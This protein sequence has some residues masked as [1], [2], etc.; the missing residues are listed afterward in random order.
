[1]SGPSSSRK[2][3]DPDGERDF[4]QGRNSGRKRREDQ[5]SPAREAASGTDPRSAPECVRL[6]EYLRELRS[7]AGLSLAALAG[8][9]AYSKSSWERYLNGKAQPP[10][11][12]ALALC[13]EAGEAPGHCLALWE[14][15]DPAWSGRGAGASSGVSAADGDAGPEPPP[16][17]EPA[18]RPERDAPDR[19]GDGDATGASDG[20]AARAPR[21]AAGPSKPGGAYGWRRWLIG[22]RLPWVVA[23][24]VGALVLCGSLLALTGVFGQDDD[25]SG[26]DGRGDG[27]GEA[28][29][30]PVCRGAECVGKHPEKT[31]CGKRPIRTVTSLRDDESGS[32]R[33]V[34]IR[35]QPDCAAGWARLWGQEEGDRFEVS[36]PGAKTQRLVIE[37]YDTG[38]RL[39][40]PMVHLK[41]D[42]DRAAEAMRVCIERPGDEGS[43]GERR[44]FGK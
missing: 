23:A 24:V 29:R 19:P 10:R 43:E 28:A 37:E 36:A 44:C 38:R 7:R 12:A 6:A 1:M 18:E 3:Q 21:E 4:G 40:T 17:P 39:S 41:G 16:G 30:G 27:R 20:D 33:Q 5:P 32:L 26:R 2:G 9:T 13:A 14:L 34:D 31:G 25:G 8:R 42:I 15:A 35:Y 11:Q 22:R